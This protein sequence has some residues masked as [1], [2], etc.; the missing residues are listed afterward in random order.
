MSLYFEMTTEMHNQIMQL[1]END[2]DISAYKIHT[3]WNPLTLDKQRI[4]NDGTK[5]VFEVNNPTLLGTPDPKDYIKY[6]E[7]DGRNILD[8]MIEQ[9]VIL[10]WWYRKP[11]EYNGIVYQEKSIGSILNSLEDYM[12]NKEI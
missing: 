10:R 12:G 8:S 1:I 6:G 9:G 4:S 7:D 11:V 5:V 2:G 3:I